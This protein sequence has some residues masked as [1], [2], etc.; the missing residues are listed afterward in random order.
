MHRRAIARGRAPD[1]L[2][3]FT[4]M[5]V[6][7]GRDEAEARAKHDEYRRYADYEAS[8]LFGLI[9]PAGL[10]PAA[11]EKIS[12]EVRRSSGRSSGRD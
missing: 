1:D 5:T 6:I 3:I 4:L 8:L 7:T 11:L 9:A 10:P 12:T 2:I